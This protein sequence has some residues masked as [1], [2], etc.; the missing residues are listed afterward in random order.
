MS[1]VLDRPKEVLPKHLYIYEDTDPN[2]L[3]SYY[4]AADI[5]VQCSRAEGFGKPI[6]EA[7]A[8]GIPSISILW[9]GPKDFCTEKNSFPV[10]YTLVKSS[11]HVQSKKTES[12]WADSKVEEIR[13]IMRFC[14]ENTDEV[15]KRGRQALIDSDK[16]LMKNVVFDVL[17]FV[18][19]YNL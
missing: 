11:Y 12:V 5:M 10:P 14:F 6:V 13:K 18:R 17:K 2:I 8:L 9:S 19:K 3:P 1:N 15:K 7:M 16:W 4:A